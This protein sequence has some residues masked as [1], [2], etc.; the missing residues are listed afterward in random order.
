MWV[1]PK[2]GWTFVKDLDR[3]VKSCSVVHAP[4]DL[5][6][7]LLELPETFSH[8][9]FPGAQPLPGAAGEPAV[10]RAVIQASLVVLRLLSVGYLG[11]S[12]TFWKKEPCWLRLTGQL[13]GRSYRITCK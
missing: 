5:I 12:S 6:S 4:R 9:C 8:N 11:V 1:S 13:R 3:S 7:N 10:R 2:C